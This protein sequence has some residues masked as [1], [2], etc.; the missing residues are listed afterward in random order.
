MVRDHPT[1]VFTG[2]RGSGRTQSPKSPPSCPS[3]VT[4]WSPGKEQALL[5]T[6]TMRILPGPGA[7]NEGLGAVPGLS[8]AFFSHQSLLCGQ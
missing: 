6:R 1:R 8:T 2:F 7:N 3:S 4:S 5:C